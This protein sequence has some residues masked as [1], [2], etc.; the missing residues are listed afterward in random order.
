MHNKAFSEILF[1]FVWHYECCL[2]KPATVKHVSPVRNPS[3]IS[4]CAEGIFFQDSL[5]CILCVFSWDAGLENRCILWIPWCNFPAQMAF[6]CRRRISFGLIKALQVPETSYSFHLSF[7]Y[8]FSVEN[9]N[10]KLILVS[11][12]YLHTGKPT[13]VD[14]FIVQNSNYTKKND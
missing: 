11:M 4:H 6:S 7:I 3:E 2:C 14:F 8:C 9:S 5:F 10:E 13:V 1:L 12:T